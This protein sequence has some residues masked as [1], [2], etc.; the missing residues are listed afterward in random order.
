MWHL[1]YRTQGLTKSCGLFS[2][3]GV[4]HEFES[5][6]KLSVRLHISR[7]FRRLARSPAQGLRSPMS[8]SIG[9]SLGGST[10]LVTFIDIVIDDKFSG[11]TSDTSANRMNRSKIQ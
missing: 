11:K 5:E 8:E 2:D 4:S 6:P 10:G 9:K 1:S 3:V 7:S